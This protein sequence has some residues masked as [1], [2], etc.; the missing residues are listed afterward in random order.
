MS[1]KLSPDLVKLAAHLYE[2]YKSGNAVAKRLDVSHSTAYRLLQAAGVNLPDRHGPE[3]QQRKKKLHGE[4]ALSA[5]KDYGSGMSAADLVAKYDCS[6]W[7]IR[8]AAKDA[9]V[10]MR[11]R[12]GTYRRF[13]QEERDEA[14]RLYREEGLSQA[15][16]AAKFNA[17]QITVSRVLRAAGV[18]IRA[19]GASGSDHGSWKGGRTKSGDYIAVYVAT[20]DPIAPMR[21]TM[22]YV[23]EH[24]AVMARELGRPLSPH[25]TVHHINGDKTDNRISNL[26]LR[27]GKH[28]K[29]VAMVCA[30]CGSHEITYRKLDD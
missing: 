4:R 22:G 21:N 15:A 3:V 25:E 1:R 17:H 27:F 20:D 14:A 11:L 9:G 2:E 30:K 29:G 8:T 13:S 6:I 28:G 23:L 16:I 5:A 24:R 12:G 18:V 19:Y 26:Q 10:S 7:A